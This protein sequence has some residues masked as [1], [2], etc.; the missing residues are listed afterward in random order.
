M[1]PGTGRNEPLVVSARWVIPVDGPALAH[2]TV[3]MGGGRILAVEPHGRRSADVD[4][5]DA[6]I[7]PGLVNAH[8]HLDL[9]GLRG[10]VP[11][12]PDFTA[13]LRAVIEHRHGLTTT[14][15]EADVSTGVAESLAAGTTLVGDIS[16]GGL[17][18][19]TVARSP[20]SAVVF[21]E[22]IGLTRERARQAWA[23]ACRWLASRPPHE[24]VSPGLSPHAPYSV[25]RSLF[26]LADAYAR[27][28]HV[29]LMIHL[30]ESLAE[31]ELL[32]RRGGPFV[33]F[34]LGLGVYD[35]DGLVCQAS[36]VMRLTA[37][38]PQLLLAHG[39]YLDTALPIPPSAT[40]VYCPR[41]HAAF[42]HRAHPFRAL[43][44]RGVRVA[45]GTDSLASNPDLDVL[46]EA[47]YL[48]RRFP[49]LDGELLLRMATLWGAEALGRGHETGSLTPGKWAD[50]VVVP[51]LT[52]GADPYAMLLGSP[53]RPVAVMCRGR[54]VAGMAPAG[55]S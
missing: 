51:L 7:L 27:R 53:H 35:P 20:L 2:G 8:T 24:Q 26:R 37:G 31:A 43:V 54:W 1:S 49:E 15:I 41:T 23:D 25:R 5:G 48:H 10:R 38:A 18:W 14:A 9:S 4:L 3:A 47:R 29:P 45:L 12:S 28:H 40:I 50:L 21:H 19:D 17:S 16:A 30:A 13:W 44:A 39:N 11:P 46:A 22:L 42:G 33:E 32:E 6:A 34:L 55:A 36:E 52:D